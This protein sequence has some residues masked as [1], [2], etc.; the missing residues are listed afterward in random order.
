MIVRLHYGNI[1]QPIVVIRY[2]Y[3]NSTCPIQARVN[4]TGK[5]EGEL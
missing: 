1:M 5:G 4:I 2:L 3:S